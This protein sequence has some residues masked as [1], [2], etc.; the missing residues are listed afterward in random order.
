MESSTVSIITNGFKNNLF[1]IDFYFE[2]FGSLAQ[3]EDQSAVED[4]NQYFKQCMDELGI[5][6][7]K[8]KEEQNF[9]SEDVLI[10]AKKI[11]KAPKLSHQNFEILSRSSFLMLNNYFEYLLADLLTYYYQ[12]FKESLNEK[13]FK[14]TLK[15][16]NE[17]ENIQEATTSLILKEVESMMIDFSFHKLLEHFENELGIELEN[18]IIN[19]DKIEEFRERRHLI[20][21][22]SSVVNKKYIVRTNNPY[23]LKQG[24]KV[25]ISIEY[26]NEA[27]KEFYLAGLL[28]CY[29]CWGKWD[30]EN[31]DQALKDMLNESFD[32]LKLEKYELVKRI[33]DYTNKI[34]ARNEEQENVLLRAK[35]NR[36]IALKKLNNQTDLK[37]DLKKIKVGTALPLFQLGHAIL[38]EKE[39]S[40]LPLFKQTKALEDVDLDK[41]NE[42]PLYS[43]VREKEDLNEQVLNILKEGDNIN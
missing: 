37:K 28:L 38:S 42:W 41:Y 43:F 34:D 10:F 31:A 22:N 11:L 2:K 39:D 23:N 12:K 35:F 13:N 29:N 15:E 26:F 17:F 5:D 24:D 40:I 30:K 33:T 21:H 36:C 27:F 18:Q 3:S 7:T 32:N 16:L 8:P 14:I 9:S 25:N 1:A 20:V 4:K 6:K 19:W